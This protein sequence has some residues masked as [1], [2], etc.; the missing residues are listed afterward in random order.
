MFF[1]YDVLACC[2]FLFCLVPV[3]FLCFVFIAFSPFVSG[4]ADRKALHSNVSCVLQSKEF[5][6]ARPSIVFFVCLFSV[7]HFV[8]LFLRRLARG[9]QQWSFQASENN[10]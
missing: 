4:G 2:L 8:C 5:V 6:S 3:L 10:P 9:E 1:F 7:C